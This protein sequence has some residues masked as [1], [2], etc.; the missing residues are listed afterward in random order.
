VHSFRLLLEAVVSRHSAEEIRFSDVLRLRLLNFKYLTVQIYGFHLGT[1]SLQKSTIRETVQ[2]PRDATRHK[3]TLSSTMSKASG[4]NSK[5]KKKGRVDVPVGLA[6]PGFGPSRGRFVVGRCLGVGAQGSVHAIVD[7]NNKESAAAAATT[8]SAGKEV[9]YA[10]KIA[11]HP[12][13]KPTPGEKRRKL[14]Q[15]ELNVRSLFSEYHYYLSHFRDFRGTVVPDV[16]SFG[17]G[18]V[19]M[20]GEIE[21]GDGSPGTYLYT[22]GDARVDVSRMRHFRSH[23]P[24]FV[25]SLFS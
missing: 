25:V 7:N 16:P 20:Y 23:G 19:P 24:L 8:T 9:G 6:L 14:P 12:A 13:V 1:S 17:D 5:K 21:T 11:R 10:A 15:E 18:N 2:S 3:P 4:S 22:Y